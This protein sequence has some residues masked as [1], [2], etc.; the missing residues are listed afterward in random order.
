MG[1]STQLRSVPR[2]PVIASESCTACKARPTRALHSLPSWQ[3]PAVCQSSLRTVAR[4]GVRGF[5]PPPGCASGAPVDWWIVMKKAFGV[6]YMYV[7]NRMSGFVV[8]KHSLASPF[9]P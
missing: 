2:H 3:C 9:E 5:G 1:G 8:S 6:G 4:G 7:D